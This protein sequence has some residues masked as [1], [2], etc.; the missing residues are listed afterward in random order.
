MEICLDSSA[1]RKKNQ[2]SRQQRRKEKRKEKMEHERLSLKDKI[3]SQSNKLKKK[4]NL[5][6]QLLTSYLVV[7]LIN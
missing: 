3:P 6:R 2:I 7:I 1:N 5:F 4:F